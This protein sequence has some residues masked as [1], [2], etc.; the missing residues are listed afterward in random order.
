MDKCGSHVVEKLLEGAGPR[1]RERV[2]SQLIASQRSLAE[3]CMDK[4][5]NHVCQ[6][7]LEGAGPLFGEKFY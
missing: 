2:Y 7:L 5:G 3:V 4:Y 6:K 1:F